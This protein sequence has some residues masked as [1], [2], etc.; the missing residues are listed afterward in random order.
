[1]LQVSR[2]VCAVCHP[3]LVCGG[4]CAAGA[5]AA[6][7]VS[8]HT[9]GQIRLTACQVSRSETYAW[10]VCSAR[11]FAA[12]D[13]LPCDVLLARLHLLVTANAAAA[14]VPVS[15]HTQGQVRL[16]ARQVGSSCGRTAWGHF[17]KLGSCFLAFWVA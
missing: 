2:A 12:A 16:T 15:T 14:A 1:V 7:P 13:V 3:G 9:Q 17:L 5:A 6:V 8:T 11:K 10:A 4:V